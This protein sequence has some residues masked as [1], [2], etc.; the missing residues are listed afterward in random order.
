M[1][2]YTHLCTYTQNKHTYICI[3]VQY[4]EIHTHI[5]IKTIG[6][7]KHSFAARVSDYLRVIKNTSKLVL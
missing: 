7:M 3:Q 1:H 4:V 6:K 2:V 5:M